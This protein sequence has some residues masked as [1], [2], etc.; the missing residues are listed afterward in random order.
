MQIVIHRETEGVDDGFEDGSDD[1]SEDGDAEKLS[2]KVD[3]RVDEHKARSHMKELIRGEI[4]Q[5]K[6]A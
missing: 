1:G 5:R 2:P 3:E 4:A 6:V